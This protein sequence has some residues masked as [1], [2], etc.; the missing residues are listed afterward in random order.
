MRDLNKTVT[1]QT[2]RSLGVT[3][4]TYLQEKARKLPSYQKE[5]ESDVVGVD[6]NGTTIAV[7]TVGR[8]LFGV[9][10]Y[11]GQLR[12]VPQEETVVLHYPENS[13]GFV[14]DFLHELKTVIEQE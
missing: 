4:S 11:Q 1:I 8:W 7:N 9:P 12:V 5:I 13:P 10:G 2:P 6:K 3:A 14:D